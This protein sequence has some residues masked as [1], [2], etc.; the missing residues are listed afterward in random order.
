M[1]EPLIYPSIALS[2]TAFNVN[3]CTVLFGIAFKFHACI[4]NSVATERQCANLLAS[5]VCSYGFCLVRYVWSIVCAIAMHRTNS[6]IWFISVEQFWLFCMCFS[7][8]SQSNCG[9]FT[10]A[11]PF[12]SLAI[13][14][15]LVPYDL[16]WCESILIGTLCT[17]LTTT[18]LAKC[19]HKQSTAQC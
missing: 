18:P 8:S 19:Q 10:V 3:V 9:K 14:S 5:N 12:L 2:L 7:F 1:C 15:V 13:C 6:V 11:S 17:Q 16:S 4:N